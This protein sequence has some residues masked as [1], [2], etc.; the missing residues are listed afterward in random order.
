MARANEEAHVGSH[1][2][3]GHGDILTVRKHKLRMITEF[4]DVAEDVVPATTVEAWCAAKQVVVSN[5]HNC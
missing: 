5:I 2:G 3:A 4:L 1:E